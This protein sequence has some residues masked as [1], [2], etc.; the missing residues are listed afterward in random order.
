MNETL[1]R[2][3]GPAADVPVSP[4][5]SSADEYT[6]LDPHVLKRMADQLAH[7]LEMFKV[8]QAYHPSQA[9]AIDQDQGNAILKN[10]KTNGLSC[11]QVEILCKVAEGM[12]NKEIAAQLHVSD[13][14]VKNHMTHILDRLYANDTGLMLWCLHTAWACWTW[15]IARPTETPKALQLCLIPT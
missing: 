6:T 1:Y 8:K 3:H 10:P 12:S 14:T 9:Q 15:R 4:K 2:V 11:R 5:V 7:V 13:Q